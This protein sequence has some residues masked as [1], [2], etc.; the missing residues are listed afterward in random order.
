M[1]RSGY[2]LVAGVSGA[3]FGAGL[4]VSQMVDPQKVLRFLD[5]TAIP[6]GGWDP[7]LAFVMGGG[8]LVMFIAVQY[9]RGRQAPLFDQNF[10]EPEYTR[11]DAPLVVGSALFGIGWGMSGI[12][13][14]PAISL[15]AFLP[16]NLWIFLAAMFIGSYLGS[17]VMRR[18][19]RRAVPA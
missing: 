11:I 9:G 19:D 14:G 6:T 3:L 10:H 8:L 17:F 4:Y 1:H 13:P 12:C 16:D 7:S 5:F 18:M 2:L 15:V